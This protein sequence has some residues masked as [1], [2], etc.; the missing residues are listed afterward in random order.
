MNDNN[1]EKTYECS[2]GV[3]VMFGLF[4][5]LSCLIF[6]QMLTIIFLTIYFFNHYFFLLIYATLYAK[7]CQQAIWA[8]HRQI[9][10]GVG[11][12][13]PSDALWHV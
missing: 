2:V 7:S 6:W 5:Y 11:V 13:S 10:H 1:T 3:G 9:P 8:I 12:C 4:Y